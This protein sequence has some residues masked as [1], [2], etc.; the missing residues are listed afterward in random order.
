MEKLS[1]YEAILIL[2]KAFPGITCKE[3]REAIERLQESEI[4][5]KTNN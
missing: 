1:V 5:E 4:V 3:A 2:E